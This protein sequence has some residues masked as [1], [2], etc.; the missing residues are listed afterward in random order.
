MRMAHHRPRKVQWLLL[1]AL[2]A[3][4]GCGD[5]G[6]GTSYVLGQPSDVQTAPGSYD[7]YEVVKGCPKSPAQFAVRG[8]G[9]QI[10][11]GTTAAYQ[12]CDAVGMPGTVFGCGGQGIAC[13][14]DGAGLDVL[15]WRAVDPI[16]DRVG[17]FL[18]DH[19]W[20][21]EVAIDVYPPPLE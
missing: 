15:D 8:L 17:R 10:V 21:L 3:S 14:T 5:S 1:L 11:G 13:T 20:S 18:K 19:D 7:G 4:P 2:A 6:Q 16:I 9:S 12:V